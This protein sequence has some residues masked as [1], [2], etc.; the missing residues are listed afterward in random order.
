MTAQWLIKLDALIDGARRRDAIK[1]PVL[2]KIARLVYYP[3]D[4]ILGLPKMWSIKYKM[5]HS[6]GSG[7]EPVKL[8]VVAI[9]K[10]ESEYIAEWVAYHKAVGVERIFLFDN[11]STDGMK[12]CIQQFINDGF[13]V[14]QQI[15]GACQQFNAYCQGLWKYGR[16]CKYMAF[17][18]C[19]EL[20]TPVRHG[21]NIVTILD[22]LFAKYPKAGGVLVN[23][24]MFGSSHCEKKPEGLLIDNFVYRAKIGKEGTNVTKSIV[25][26]QYTLMWNHPHF[27][28]YCL[29]NYGIDM[30]GK[31]N[32]GF[33]NEIDDY[34]LLK[35]NHYFT[36]S[37]E[38]WIK[39]RSQG[40]ADLGADDKRT[41]AEFIAHDNND[42]LDESAKTYSN[43]VK[44]IL[45]K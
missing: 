39:R 5:N 20:L 33:W 12:N 23:W 32:N 43:Q 17:I 29:G 18:D 36:K 34:H 10:N 19:D 11:D 40:K 41:M 1:I 45:N 42:V 22:D 35:V 15:H 4:L 25:R 28:V 38:Q 30:T 16:E 44:E 37:K 3:I 9:A 8:A 2:K 13:V 27:P 6:H 31:R 24:C 26:P 14:Y 7:L 21:D